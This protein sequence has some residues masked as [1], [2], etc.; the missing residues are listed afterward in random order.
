MR[1]MVLVLVVMIVM[2]VTQKRREHIAAE[3]GALDIVIAI[4]SPSKY[5]AKTD[6]VPKLVSIKDV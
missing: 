2:T 6:C 3:R 1:I 4:A 5:Y